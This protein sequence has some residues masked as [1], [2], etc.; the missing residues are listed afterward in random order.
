[1]ILNSIS[2][3]YSRQLLLFFFIFLSVCEKRLSIHCVAFTTFI[4]VWFV[5]MNVPRQ[6][7]EKKVYEL[8]ELNL[9][10]IINLILISAL[11]S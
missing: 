5:L 11:Y 7:K 8:A 10:L 6:N 9:Q 4:P 3:I 2:Y 1:M